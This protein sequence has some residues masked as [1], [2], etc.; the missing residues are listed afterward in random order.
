MCFSTALHRPVGDL[1]PPPTSWPCGAGA[2]AFL[3]ARPIHKGQRFPDAPTTALGTWGKAA[4]VPVGC[5]GP[6]LI[7]K[8]C[9]F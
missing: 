9:S 7:H 2:G 5:P 4:S 1:A 8:G 3:V 6:P